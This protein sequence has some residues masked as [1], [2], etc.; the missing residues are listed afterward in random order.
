M[1]RYFHK[2]CVPTNDLKWPIVT[3][4]YNFYHTLFEGMN[5]I[6]LYVFFDCAFHAPMSNYWSIDFY[7]CFFF[8]LEANL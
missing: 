7:Y 4:D 1:N 2:L 3:G 8:I 5:L 6:F